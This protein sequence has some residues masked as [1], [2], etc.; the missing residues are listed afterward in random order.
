MKH[1]RKQTALTSSLRERPF[2]GVYSF[3]KNGRRYYYYTATRKAKKQYFKSEAGTQKFLIE[4]N[5]FCGLNA[6]K[7]TINKKN[8]QSLISQYKTSN[9]FIDLKPST[10][11]TKNSIFDWIC[12]NVPDASL[13]DWTAAHVEALMQRKGGA[14]AGN[15]VKIQMSLLFTYAQRIGWCPQGHNPAQLAKRRVHK[16]KGF[17]TWTAEEVEA[18]EK[19]HPH[20]SEARLALYLYMATGASKVDGVNL[21]WKD[22]KDGKISF[23]R[24]KTGQGRSSQ[25]PKFLQ[26]ELD[27][28]P[29]D[30]DYFLMTSFGKQYSENG[31]GNKFKRW[32]GQAGIPHC[33]IHGL[34]KVIAVKLANLGMSKHHIGAW[35]AHAGTDQVDTYTQDA[36]REAL[37]EDSMKALKWK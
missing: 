32:T 16:T 3:V 10:K 25:I 12:D 31:F 29:A 21:G 19:V 6:K 20:G 13:T 28:I 36:D 2:K 14:E 33:T 8:I 30:Q 7:K 15:R 1:L 24:L 26:D 22:V 18:F 9:E 23:D 11:K 34:R 5:K 37:I 27:L 4:Y 35:L 17:H